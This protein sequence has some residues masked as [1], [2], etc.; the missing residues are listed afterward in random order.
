MWRNC[1]I[2]QVLSTEAFTSCC[3][4]CCGTMGSSLPRHHYLFAPTRCGRP[5]CPHFSSSCSCLCPRG[6]LCCLRVMFS[7][8]ASSAFVDLSSSLIACQPCL[9]TLTLVALLL[10]S[11][12][13][14]LVMSL[15]CGPRDSCSAVHLTDCLVH[16]FF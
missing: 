7:A 2:C 13:F 9:Q 10:P 3:Q 6:C 12:L 4:A 1:E 11:F 8:F 15:W 5:Y 16:F 14:F